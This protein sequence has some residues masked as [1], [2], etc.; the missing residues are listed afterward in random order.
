MCAGRARWKIEN[1][2]FNTLKNQGYNFEHN[3]GPG[4]QNLAT[5]LA[6]LMFLACTVDQLMQRCGRLFRQVRGGL[7]TKAQLWDIVRSLFKVQLFPTMDALY[8]QIADLYDI[9]LC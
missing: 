9:Q 3:Y 2:T 1:E 8:R 7:R 6:L 4:K 5:V